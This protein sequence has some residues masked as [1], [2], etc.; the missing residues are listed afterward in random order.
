MP[1]T[2]VPDWILADASPIE[3]IVER[4]ILQFYRDRLIG[5]FHEEPD[6]RLC[7]CVRIHRR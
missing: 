3:W 5:A 6:V 4:T 7:Q 1:L 2:I